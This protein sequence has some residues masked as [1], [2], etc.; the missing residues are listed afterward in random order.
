MSLNLDTVSVWTCQVTGTC[1]F[2]VL[3]FVYFF[4]PFLFPLFLFFIPFLF[5]CSFDVVGV[6]MVENTDKKYNNPRLLSY[7][8]RKWSNINGLIFSSHWLRKKRCCC[9]S[10]LVSNTASKEV[11]SHS[12]FK[13][14]LLIIV[15][16]VKN[17]PKNKQRKKNS[18]D[19]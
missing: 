2:W 10:L 6:C 3:L 16:M 19:I 9:Y 7:L 17:M 18:I 15:I 1:K 4:F 11:E 14:K 5:L 12:L 8:F 13:K